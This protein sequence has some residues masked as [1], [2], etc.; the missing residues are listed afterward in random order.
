M[1]ARIA[2]ELYWIGRQLARAEHTSRMLD[3][4]F[5]A[6]LQGRPD[7]PAGVR[8]SWD[9]LLTIVSGEPPETSASRDDVLRLLTLDPEHPTSVLNCIARAREGARTVRDVF[10]GEMWEAINTFHL[11]LLQRNVSAAVQTGPYSV[12]AYVRERCGLFWGV[13]GR[14]MLRDEA[15]AFLQAGRGDRVRRHGA[16]DA[17]R[18]AA[19]RRRRGPRRTCAT[20]RRSRCCRPSAASRPT[21]ARC[22]R[23]RTR[24][25]VARFLLFERDYPDSVAFSIEALHAALTAADPS[26]R[27]SPAVLRLSRL[28]ADLDF[29]ART[30]DARRRQ[31]RRARS[32]PSSSSSR[33]VDLDI[34]GRYFG[35]ARAARR[36][37]GRRMNFAIRYLTEY[38]YDAPVT[39]NLNALRVKPATMAT[40]SVE[41]FVVRV[42]PES[43]LNQHLDYFGT[44][45]IE[46]GISRPHEHLAI[47]VRARVR[48]IGA[49]TC[50]RRPTGRRS[51]TAPTTPP[52]ASSCCSDGSEPDDVAI[53][54]LVG[55]TRADSPLATVQQLIEVIPDR[56][57]YRAGV[58]YVGSTVGDLLAAGAGVCQDFA[59]LALLLL[60]RHGIG[61]RYV[62]GYLWAPPAAT[63]TPP[64]PR[65][66]PTRG[67]RR[68]CPGPNGLDLGLRRPDQPHARRR[69]PRQDRPRPPLRR[70]AADQGRLPRRARSR[71]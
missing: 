61:A 34:A 20:A 59:H 60:R 48:T 40:Q 52:R 29:R 23:R 71:S 15:H 36:A 68:C 17:A 42:E 18:R 14:T 62:S 2:H 28:M 56:F 24:G 13:T 67:S 30:A 25:P 1:L 26:Y 45:V 19:R 44:T 38:R 64:R 39:D 65:S 53:D 8:L 46:F 35:D 43:R 58:T 55:L 22:P 5:H 70:R 4:V 37:P 33:Q 50:R 27:S 57:E 10:S 63:R 9:A 69:E 54:D 12:Y 3:G 11:G 7:D 49:R 66:R 6:D 31:R 21:G 51:R 41:D 32:A 16:A 47:D